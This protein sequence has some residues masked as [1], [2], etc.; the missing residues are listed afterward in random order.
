MPTSKG[1]G[2]R[3]A[4]ATVCLSGTLEEKLPA[5]AE[6]GF[7]G[8]EIFEPDL[9][10]A[11]WTPSEIRRRCQDLGL[12]IDLYQPF[13]DFEAVPPA[14]YQENLRRA[15]RKF[16]VM[17]ELGTDTI[18][19]CSSVSPAAIDDDDLAAEQLNGLATRAAARGLRVAYEALAWGRFVNTWDHSWQIVQKGDHPALGLCLDSFHVL[20][21][22]SETAGIAALPAG[23]VFFLQLADAPP[24]DMGI[25]QWSRHHR[26]FPGQGNFDLVDFLGLVLGTGYDGPLSLEVFNDVFR[27]S[28][29]H[30]TAVDALRSLLALQE[31]LARSKGYLDETQRAQLVQPPA[32]P[33]TQGYAFGELSVDG[34]SGPRLAE[35]LAELGF[36]HAGQHRSKPVQLWQQGRA[37][38]LLNWGADRSAELGTAEISAFAVQTPD[39]ASSI[40]RAETL[41]A[42]VLPRPTSPGEADL[43][44]VA[45]PDGTSVFFC[46]PGY[47]GPSTTSWLG[48]FLPTGA[49]LVESVGLT[50]IDHVALTQP[51]DSFDEAALFY[52]SVL[53][54]EP[55]GLIEFAAP[56]GM[57]RSR[58][59]KN[60]SG[61]VRIPL[62][63]TLLR[64][65]WTPHQQDPQHIAFGCDDIF[66]AAAILHERGAPL[67]R[68]PDNYYDDL[69]AR[70]T[71]DP[72]LLGL[73]RE[74]S[75]LYDRDADGEFFQLYTEV[76]GSRVFGEI[77]Q[78]VGDYDGYGAVNTPVHMAAHHRLR[79]ANADR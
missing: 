76:L 42:A 53:G 4:I 65:A 24:L 55:Q 1:S 43:A 45:A 35:V 7:H 77:V 78:R 22:G 23:S 37:R 47:D 79:I 14:L 11:P 39:A 38:V 40:E 50:H 41:L 70:L 6:A 54:L 74:Y 2:Y 29:P 68:V 15:E 75:I 57:L 60:E 26:L 51:F 69:D 16:D 20:S 30:R 64:R 9:V 28:E 44:A 56:I 12:S 13:R 59:M 61:T 62:S 3:T 5:A 21:R 73:M 66:A 27:Q 49:E 19:A 71:L 33:P 52:R 25:M 10:T 31:Q 17:E 58:A 34:R 18:L 72:G 63:V 48:D 46:E 67:L 36:T 8:V 32:A